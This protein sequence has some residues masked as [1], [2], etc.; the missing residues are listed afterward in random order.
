MKNQQKPIFRN[1]VV[2]VL[3]GLLLISGT[4]YSSAQSQDQY[5]T[6]AGADDDVRSLEISREL[7]TRQLAIENM[8]SDLGIYDL[9]LIEAYSD[10]GAFYIELEDFESAIRLYHEALQ[11]ARINTGLYSEQQ[12]P[13]INALIDNNG[14]LEDWE[15]EN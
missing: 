8:Q 7:A 2:H 6:T 11:I 3:A 9:S 4:F 1:I 10:L 13:A 12:M 14:K 5:A 15:E